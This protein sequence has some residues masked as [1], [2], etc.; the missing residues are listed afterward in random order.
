MK[1]GFQRAFHRIIKIAG[2]KIGSGFSFGFFSWKGSTSYSAGKLSNFK[3]P[4]NS[5]EFVEVGFTTK[6]DGFP[7]R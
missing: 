6:L 3:L 5:M 1:Q 4:K 2:R 7:Y